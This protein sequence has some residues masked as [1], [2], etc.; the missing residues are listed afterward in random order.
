MGVLNNLSRWI[1]SREKSIT[2]KFI[3]FSLVG[4]SNTAVDWLVFF[5]LVSVSPFFASR[6][7]LAKAASFAVAVVNSFIL[8]SLWTFRDEVVKGQEN[9]VGFFAYSRVGKFFVTALAGLGINSLAFSFVRTVSSSLPNLHSQLLSLALATGA[10][11]IWNFVVNLVWTYQV[12]EKRKTSKASKIAAGVIFLTLF[13][14]ALSALNDSVTTDEIPHIAAGYSYI[15]SGKMLLNLEH[16]PLGKYIAAL[17][18]TALSLDPPALGDT[19]EEIDVEGD[20]FWLLQWEWGFNLIFGQEVS[21][22]LVVFLARLPMILLFGLA[23]WFVYLLGRD[24]FGSRAGLA[25]LLLFSFSPNFLAHGRLVATDVGVTFGFVATLYFL[26]RYIKEER[27]TDLLLTGIFLGLANLFKFSALILYPVLGL[28]LVLKFFDLTRFWDS[29]VKVIK[30]CLPV[31]FAGLFT[32]LLGYYLLFP[33]DVCCFDPKEAFFL[34]EY[35]ADLEELSF[36]ADSLGRPVLNYISGVKAVIDRI[37]PGNP[38]FIFGKVS[39]S[40]WWYFFPVS[41]FFKEPIPTVLGALGALCF[42]VWALLRLISLRFRIAFLVIPFGLY[43]L[44]AVFSRFNLGIRHIIP[45]LSFLYILIGSAVSYLWER[46]SWAPLAVSVMG[47]WLVLGT[48]LSFPN[49][50]AYFNGMHRV[51]GWDKHEV[52][53][54]SNLQ[55]GQNL[56]RLGRFVREQNIEKIKVD[57]WFDNFPNPFYVPQALNWGEGFDN[58]VEWYAVGVTPF[59]L[60]KGVKGD[61]YEF[62]RDEEPVEIVGDGILVYHMQN[63]E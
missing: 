27:K 29:A 48:V 55:W 43:I 10:S 19:A 31:F 6:E 45:S 15:E 5:V 37:R 40:S 1:H 4:V 11:L 49:Y 16:P 51:L 34:N 32:T 21:H 23:A 22:E 63:N 42:A 53:V 44:L 7:V 8:N 38:P 26:H 47:I 17:P 14:T 62:L 36:L 50:I 24:M 18:L 9:G 35:Y 59:Q 28:I 57:A 3:R 41:F 12:R 60:T 58:K 56:I 25:S 2:K 13:I 54:D 52:F 61:P 39:G 46:V 33:G 20:P 30:S